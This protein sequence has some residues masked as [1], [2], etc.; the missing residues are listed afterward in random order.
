MEGTKLWTPVGK[1]AKREGVSRI[2]IQNWIEQGR[3]P[4]VKRTKGGRYRIWVEFEPE[5]ILYGRISSAKQKSSLITQEKILKKEYPNGNFISDVGS[6]FN[7]K[8]RQFVTILERSFNGVSIHLVATT[9]DRITR[10]GF[11]LIKR[12]IELSGGQVELLEEFDKPE[13]FDTKSLIGF[14]TSFINSHYGKR[15]TKRKEGNCNKQKN[16]DFPKK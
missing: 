9:Q 14:I 2:T 6:G 16:T 13:E 11:G 3:Y 12:I 10:T 15:S 5:V 1:I 8:R 4:K 7:F